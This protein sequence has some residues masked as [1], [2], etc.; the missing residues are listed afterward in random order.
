MKRKTTALT[1]EPRLSGRRRWRR[2]EAPPV[3]VHPGR[4][5]EWECQRVLEISR[6][7]RSDRGV[8]EETKIEREREG[9][10]GEISISRFL[11]LSL[12]LSAA[13]GFVF[14]SVQRFRRF[15]VGFPSVC[16]FVRRGFVPAKLIAMGKGLV[17]ILMNGKGL[18]WNYGDSLWFELEI[19][20]SWDKI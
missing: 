3:N 7:V 2:G 4:P 10:G 6:S 9:F 14:W 8:L 20:K 18:D 12:L 16:S 11:S 19:W 1:F 15:V 5:R 17:G 13:L